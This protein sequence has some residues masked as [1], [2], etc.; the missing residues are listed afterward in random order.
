VR[1]AFVTNHT[2]LD[3]SSRQR[4]YQYLPGLRALGLEVSVHPF[5]DEALFEVMHAPGHLPAK[6]GGL[7][8]ASARRLGLVLRGL[9]ADVVVLHREAFP[10]GPPW[11]ETALARG[12]APVVFSFDDALYA[13]FPYAG[14]GGRRLLYRLKYGRDLG[15]VLR[16]CAAVI[17]GNRHLAE[18]ARRHNPTVTVI[19]TAVDTDALSP[20]PSRPPGR[21]TV[22]WIG[23]PSTS[24]H[25]RDVAGSLA[26][27]ATRRPE[28]DFLLV[29]DPRLAALDLPRAEV[30]AWSMAREADDLRAMDVG[31]MPLQDSEWTRGKCAFKAIQYM[32]VGAP[33]VASRLGASA[34]V[35]EDG[36]SG[37]LVDGPEGWAGA[38]EGICADP[39]LRAAMGRRGRQLAQERFSLRATLPD[40]ARV[41][42][43][44]GETRGLAPSAAVP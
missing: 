22:G 2:A 21:L 32:A 3:A 43:A 39:G 11:L 37:L 10:F 28:V 16:R 7:L 19:P 24:V 23:G 34:E 13:P 36:G 6:V 41:I 33:V 9:D 26:E 1:V 5:S 8:R 42:Q 27:L 30:R 31:L 12:R 40:L 15:P 17:A 38:L 18:Y 14:G 29:G 4:V 44:A 25:V 35:V 20:P